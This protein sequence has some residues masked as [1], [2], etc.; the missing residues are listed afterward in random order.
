VAASLALIV[1]VAVFTMVYFGARHS[2][3]TH[4]IAVTAI[5]TP[6][7]QISPSPSAARDPVATPAPNGGLG[8]VI[9]AVVA[10]THQRATVITAPAT[11]LPSPS[12][13]DT[14]F[15]TPTPTDTPTPTPTPT[16]TSTPTPT[17]TPTPTD[18]PTPT[19]AP[20]PS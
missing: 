11:V 15:P 2:G 3:A 5:E 13:T 7:P 16:D 8:T 20:S 6:T 10:T 17:P 9:R 1:L 19:P 4:A 18:T 14:A 12:P